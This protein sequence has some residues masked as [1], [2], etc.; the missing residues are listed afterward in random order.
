MF[1]LAI[2]TNGGGSTRRPAS[3]TGPVGFKPS[4]GAIAHEHALPPLL[5]DFEVIGPIARSVAD[6]QRRFDAL[7]GP[8]PAD[9]RSLAVVEPKP[10]PQTL[11]V[12]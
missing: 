5:P 6:V 12:L 11:K 9:R 10:L 8:H 4:T 2:G 3:P 1:P 7:R